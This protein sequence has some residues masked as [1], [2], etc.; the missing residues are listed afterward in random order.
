MNG[1]TC[2]QCGHPFTNSAVFIELNVETTH[3]THSFE[4]C[5]L[6]CTQR[7]IEHH[8]KEEDE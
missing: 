3:Y 8:M 2:D 5:C 7:W 6:Q 1:E 4:F